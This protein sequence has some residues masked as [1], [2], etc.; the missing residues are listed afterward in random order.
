[1]SF[2]SI[3]V[4]S[5]LSLIL[6]IVIYYLQNKKDFRLILLQK[7]IIYQ[8]NIIAYLTKTIREHKKIQKNLA[9]MVHHDPLTGLPNKM[10]YHI[11]LNKRIAIAKKKHTKIFLLYLDFDNFKDIN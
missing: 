1:M 4:I 6:C 5:L 7:L 11:L 2:I 3:L 8:N 10:L 9:H